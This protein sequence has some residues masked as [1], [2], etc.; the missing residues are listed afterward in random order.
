MLVTVLLC[1][2]FAVCLISCVLLLACGCFDLVV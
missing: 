2:C 1:F